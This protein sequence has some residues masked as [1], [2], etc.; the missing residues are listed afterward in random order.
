[1]EGKA[2]GEHVH[3]VELLGEERNARNL[4]NALGVEEDGA[5]LVVGLILV[6]NED[7]LMWEALAQCR[8]GGVHEREGGASIS[9]TVVNDDKWVATNWCG[10]VAHAVNDKRFGVLDHA[11]APERCF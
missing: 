7:L 4:F 6:H 8:D 3:V 11:E 10:H 2:A 5:P 9:C 1:M